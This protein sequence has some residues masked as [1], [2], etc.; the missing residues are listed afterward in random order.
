MRQ[1][2]PVAQRGEEGWEYAA[3]E[4]VAFVRSEDALYPY[5]VSQ[6][7]SLLPAPSGLTIDVGCGE[8]R[9]V[10]T[11]K[12]SGYRVVGVD[13]SPTLVRL[14]G[15]AD[16]GGDY[17]VATAEALPLA[18]DAARLVVSFMTLEHIADL[19]AACS[20]ASRV[21]CAG[22]S[23]C[24]SLVHP[25]R[26]GGSFDGNDQDARFVL[27]SYFPARAVKRPLF[28]AEVVAYHRPLSDYATAL[29]EAGFVI[30]RIAEL[31]S[32]RRAVGRLPMFM[33]ILALAPG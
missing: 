15:E 12:E 22:G 1:T 33:H 11:L 21:L 3:T 4:W 29:F 17:R 16:P 8:G 30:R 20:E 6:F 10:R 9:L 24:F 27:D 18:D 26:S 28:D 31:P 23:F 13:A 5:N 25:A 2:A 14:A 7:L 32:Q 19:Q